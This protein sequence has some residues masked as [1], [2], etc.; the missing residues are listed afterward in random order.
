MPTPDLH[1]LFPSPRPGSAH[2]ASRRRK[3]RL[4]RLRRTGILL[5]LLVALGF[6]GRALWNALHPM[7][8]PAGCEVS[9][10]R[11][12]PF[13][14]SPEKFANAATISAVSVKRDLPTRAAVIATA[15]ALQES[16]LR[17]LSHGDRDS[18]G[19]FQQRPSQGWGTAQQIADTVYAV[20]AFFDHL[21]KVRDWRTRPLTQVAQAVQRS[22]YPDAYAKHEAEA[23]ALAA[24]FTGDRPA[25][26]ACRLEDP[27][28]IWSR[29][30]ISNQLNRE[31]GLRARSTDTGLEISADD[32]KSAW[33]A[34][35]WAVA[36]AQDHGTRSVTVGNRTWTRTMDDRGLRW[37]TAEPA[38]GAVQVHIELAAVKS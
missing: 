31:T 30:R 10:A 20:G 34:A 16:K 3:A 29:G 25:A 35:A 15:T 24:A 11:G 2:A 19:L 28:T 4:R 32:P 13:G 6:G 12:G 23:T 14:Y 17:N 18:L 36:H 38:I 27:T 33:L 5:V 7:L 26:A 1:R 21:V 9:Q 37:E 22:G 8:L